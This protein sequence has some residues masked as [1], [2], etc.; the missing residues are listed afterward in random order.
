MND[1]LNRRSFFGVFAA[2]AALQM[3]GG[4]IVRCKFGDKVFGRWVDHTDWSP[5]GVYCIPGRG[6]V[7]IEERV[8]W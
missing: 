4:E 8:S 2:T 6:E 5:A 7:P 1:E 3:E